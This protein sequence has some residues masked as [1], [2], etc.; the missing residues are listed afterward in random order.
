MTQI[1]PDIERQ[2]EELS[3]H[4]KHLASE[5]GR[6][7]IR[8]NKLN[9]RI[10]ENN[11]RK[12]QLYKDLRKKIVGDRWFK[13]VTPDGKPSNAGARLHGTVKQF[14]LPVEGSVGEWYHHEG[15]L[16]LCNSGFHATQLPVHHRTYQGTALWEVEVSEERVN[17]S[18]KSVFRS[19]RFVREIKLNTTEYTILMSR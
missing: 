9:T 1:D 16:V 6:I 14:S 12:S 7:S 18:Q 19:I 8:L 2:I 10:I 11:A 17:S 15:P 5:Y 3:N 13:W 4:G